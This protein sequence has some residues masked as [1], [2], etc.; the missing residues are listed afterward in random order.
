MFWNPQAVL[1]MGLSSHLVFGFFNDI[2]NNTSKCFG[3]Q[4]FKNFAWFRHFCLT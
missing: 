2:Q 1:N 4:R 3:I